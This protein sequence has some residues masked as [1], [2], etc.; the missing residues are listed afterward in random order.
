MSHLYKYQI[1]P[2]HSDSDL[3]LVQALWTLCSSPISMVYLTGP[4]TYKEV[5]KAA[6]ATIAL[7]SA[8]GFEACL[9]GSA[10][11]SLYGMQHRDPN[12][13]LSSLPSYRS[14]HTNQP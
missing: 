2:P 4:P 6:R 3:F 14:M 9:F 10:A 13:R 1:I 5:R 7:L 8:N 11:C 12:V